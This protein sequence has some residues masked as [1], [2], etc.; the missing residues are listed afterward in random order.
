MKK[1]FILSLFISV[2]SL[3]IF[4]TVDA[5]TTNQQLIETLLK[6]I[7]ALQAQLQTLMAQQGVVATPNPTANIEDRTE[8]TQVTT[9]TSNNLRVGESVRATV[10]G[11]NVRNAWGNVGGIIGTIPL[12]TVGRLII[13]PN[14]AADGSMWWQ[15]TWSNGVNGWSAE[16]LISRVQNST[17]GTAVLKVISPNG[18]ESFVAGE[19]VMNITYESA[20]ISGEPLTAHLYSPTLGDIRV[21]PAGNASSG[22]GYFQMDLAKGGADPIGQYKINLCAHSVSSPIVPDKSLCDLSDNYFNLTSSVTP[23]TSNSANVVSASILSGGVQTAPTMTANFSVQITATGG[24]IQ[25]PRTGAFQFSVFRDGNIVYT[26]NL[27]TFTTNYSIPAGASTGGA[28]NTFTIPRNSTVTIPVSFTMQSS[29]GGTPI[30]RG[31][32]SVALAS[33]RPVSG[34]VSLNGSNLSTTAINFPSTQTTNTTATPTVSLLNSSDS[35]DVVNINSGGSATFR[36][37]AANFTRCQMFKNGIIYNDG[38]YNSFGVNVVSYQGTFSVHNQTQSANYTLTCTGAG[39]T[40]SDSVQVNVVN[41]SSTTYPSVS[42][43]S[44]ASGANLE[45]GKTYNVNYTLGPA[46]SNGGPYAVYLVGGALGTTGSKYIANVPSSIPNSTG[47]FSWQVPSDV[48]PSSNY[49][50]QF[51]GPAATGNNSNSFSIIGAQVSTSNSPSVSLYINSS[52]GSGSDTVSAG[53]SKVLNWSSTNSTSC[54]KSSSPTNSYWNGSAATGGS[55]STGAINQTT[56]FTVTCTGVGGSGSSSVTINVSS[57]QTPAAPTMTLTA[58]PSSIVAGQSVRLLMESSNASYC[59]W[60]SGIDSDTGGPTVYP[61]QTTTYTGACY[62]ST[63]QSTTRSV[64]VTVTPA[65]VA[66]T[67]APTVSL[68]VNSSYNFGGQTTATPGTLVVLD[69]SSSNATSCSAPWIANNPYVSGNTYGSQS[70]GYVSATNTYTVTC[71]G[72]G[73]SAS[74]SLTLTV[75]SAPAT[76]PPPTT[77]TSP[78]P[79]PAAVAP[80]VD[81]FYSSPYSISSGSGSNLYWSTTNATS[82]SITGLGS[83]GLTGAQPIYPTTS[84]GYTISC[85]GA[86][87]TV[88]SYASVNVETGNSGSDYEGYNGGDGSGDTIIY[89]PGIPNLASVNFGLGSLKEALKNLFR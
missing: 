76:T 24:D 10:D 6:Q 43:T 87:G 29:I 3:S 61:T 45:V 70:I 28:A 40:A 56:T 51:S 59:R 47:V 23:T 30:P 86:G 27:P 2:L 85:S 18:G 75:S 37:T 72:A 34:T 20:N 60:I 7:T 69:W 54:T 21:F 25:M 62:N 68:N 63:G 81:Y 5:Q 8:D 32:Y 19:G 57:T 77:Q 88:T 39:G 41:T 15:I 73:G 80:K 71:T 84:T 64:T 46:T 67:P 11:L 1:A 82:C 52:F 35:R 74:K 55:Y 65:P 50:L 9:S 4:T 22:R 12:G 78:A 83:V 89:N 31:Q 49:Q 16:R 38:V 44:P 13:G 58:T 48:T 17:N 42:I 53:S 79:S 26:I 14:R 33:I 66:T 36:W